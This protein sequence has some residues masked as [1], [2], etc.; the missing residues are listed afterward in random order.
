[1]NHQKHTV[2]IALHDMFQMYDLLQSGITWNLLKV[3]YNFRYTHLD[4]PY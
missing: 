3:Y 1:M 4:F 2:V